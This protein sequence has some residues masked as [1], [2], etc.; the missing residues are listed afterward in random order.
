MNPKAMEP[1]MNADERRWVGMI[2]CAT[3]VG[4]AAT[5]GMDKALGAT[6]GDAARGR[7][8][9]VAR[10]G[11]HCVLCHAAPGVAVAGNVGPS[12]DGVGARLSTAQLRLR[13]VDI[14][15]VKPDAA[16]PAF[17][18][19]EGLQRVAPAAAGKPVLSGQQVEDVVA[20]LGTLK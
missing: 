19:I 14:T 20:F 4:C 15:L 18:R 16:M 12:L 7:E 8:V 6:A 17:H 2:V 13:V 1:Q 3:A 5:D 11:G 10:E 9:F